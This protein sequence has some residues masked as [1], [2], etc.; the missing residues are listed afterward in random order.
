MLFGADAVVSDVDV[1]V[2]VAVFFLPATTV[3]VHD[4]ATVVAVAVST[5]VVATVL[6]LL[7]LLLP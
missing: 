1:A 6:S 7:P 3:A 5:V 2:A 4:G